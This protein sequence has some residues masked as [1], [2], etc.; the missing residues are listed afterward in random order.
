MRFDTRLRSWLR[1]DSRRTRTQHEM[2]NEARCHIPRKTK[3]LIPVSMSPEQ[4]GG[5][6]VA[7]FEPRKDECPEAL[8]L[9][10]L[11]DFRSDLRFGVRLLW[12]SPVFATVAILSLA[13][14][15]GANTAL[16]CLSMAN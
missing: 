14:G 12:R 4:A 13:L 3:D 11:H 5:R 7:E 1:P 16:F 9:R 15:I 6:A 2:D 8:G 10:L